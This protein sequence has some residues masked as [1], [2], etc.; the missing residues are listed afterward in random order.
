MSDRLAALGA[1]DPEMERIEALLRT[2]GWPVAYAVTE[3]G[4]R[5]RGGEAFRSYCREADRMRWVGGL[6]VL[7]ECDM[8]DTGY[9]T[10]DPQYTDCAAVVLRI[11]HHRPGDP[12][13]GVPPR[14]F[15]RGSSLG[16][17]LSLLSEEGWTPPWPTAKHSSHPAGPSVEWL[18]GRGP[19]VL[20]AAW[21]PYVIPDDLVLAAAADH[22]PAAAY[23]GLC[24]GVDPGCIREWR[25]RQ[26]AEFQG[27]SYESLLA[28]VEAAETAIKE[29]DWDY[30]EL[31]PA[32]G[33]D[34]DRAA[35]KDLRGAHVPE[36]PEASLRLGVAIL[37]DG[38]PDGDGRRKLNLLGD[39]T[40][41][42]VAAWLSRWAHD[43][44][45]EGIYGDPGRG[46]AGGYLPA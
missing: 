37:C 5:V 17:V 6:I 33:D 36:A 34:V 42:L 43:L 28:T 3:T 20:W 31:G 39:P 24:P 21:R 30:V 18:D 14:N 29:A 9:G 46:F 1:S 38:L 19:W 11:D 4:E 44:G 2:A 10:R 7:V 41:E 13:Y 16:Q 8:D 27:V 15:L 12:G 35:Y 40:G 32:G 22:C 45:L 23:R 26:R 25:L